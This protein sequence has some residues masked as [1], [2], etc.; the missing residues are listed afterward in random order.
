MER[1]QL[2]TALR[3]ATQVGNQEA[4]LRIAQMVKAL[5][6]KEV[7]NAQP[8]PA[9]PTATP[10]PA[11]A[12][13]MQ[14]AAPMPA[15]VPTAPLHQHAVATPM[16]PLHDAPQAQTPELSLRQPMR[17]VRPMMAPV[18]APVAPSHV[19]QPPQA[20]PQA[21]APQTA[22]FPP[23]ERQ[24][25]ANYNGWDWGADIVIDGENQREIQELVDGMVGPAYMTHTEAQKHQSARRQ[26]GYEPDPSGGE[27]AASF[28]EGLTF[29]HAG[30]LSGLVGA[31]LTSGARALG[32]NFRGDAP[33]GFGAQYQY[34]KNGVDANIESGRRD[35]PNQV[36]PMEFV[37]VLGSLAA[38]VL[39][40]GTTL[41]GRALAGAGTGA[42]YAGV[43]AMGTGEGGIAKR[44]TDAV[45]DPMTSGAAALGGAIPLAGRAATNIGKYTRQAGTALARRA[46]DNKVMP[47]LIRNRIKE[48][49]GPRLPKA[50]QEAIA[51]LQDAMH[52]GGITPAQ[53]HARAD[54]LGDDGMV[55]DFLGEVGGDAGRA[56]ASVSSIAGTKLGEEL[57]GRQL[58]Q[59][60][61]IGNAV[62]EATG[63][64]PGLTVQDAIDAM[65]AETWPAIQRAYRKAE[66]AGQG[67]DLKDFEWIGRTMEGQRAM[68][69]GRKTAMTKAIL[70]APKDFI[71]PV[72]PNNLEFL[73]AVKEAFVD[74]GQ[75]VNKLDHPTYPQTPIP[76]Q[77]RDLRT[78]IY[79]ALPE[80]GDA[81]HLARN[82]VDREEALKRGETLGGMK[83]PAN[84]Q[85]LIRLFAGVAPENRPDLWQGY[86]LTKLDQIARV[87]DRPGCGKSPGL[88]ARRD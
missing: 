42:A 67:I 64:K 68:E 46:A 57:T 88:T 36:G 16:A 58:D 30:E 55:I 40:A 73:D 38:P 31:G 8:A 87:A 15:A 5:D 14:P 27:V 51:R 37:G 22:T 78:A 76:Q 72:R 34:I 6:K 54:Q 26:L 50:Q 60:F 85:S 13:R 61:R 65:H 81:R 28:L 48:R 49:L 12:P 11:P 33:K 84:M 2:L 62:Q 69:V 47:E 75:P 63:A 21:Q 59:P 83:P 45:T 86:G 56:A 53:V 70:D 32:M 7:E 9:A 10:E 25:G 71:G 44:A 23:K 19:P 82:A 3:V 41:A 43:T 35:H 80:Y 29:G 79:D 74:A 1:E 52:E 17:P 77:A 4:A 66:N 18:G 20:A 24:D 39:R